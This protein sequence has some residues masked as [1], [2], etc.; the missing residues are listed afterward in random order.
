MKIGILTFHRVVNDGS[1]MQAFCLY[2]LLKEWI[3][4]ASIEIVDYCPATLWRRNH[5]ALIPRRWPF[6]DRSFWVK[7]R[8]GINFLR[9]N[10]RLSEESLVSDS[11]PRARAFVRRQGYDAVI[12]GSDTVWDTRKNGGAPPPPNVYFLPGLECEKR[13]AF[14]VSMDK[15]HPG[16]LAAALWSG[17]VRDLDGFVFISV[18]DEATRRHLIAGGLEP[19][20]IQFLADPTVHVDFSDVLGDVDMLVARHQPLAGVAVSD[21]DLRRVITDQFCQAGYQVINLL[22][23]TA[24]GQISIPRAWSLGQRVAVH[25]ELQALITDRFHAAVFALKLGRARVLMVE[26][27]AFYPQ[28]KSKGRDLF[29]R[30]GMEERVWRFGRNAEIPG[31]LVKLCVAPDHDVGAGAAPVGGRLEKLTTGSSGVLE[32]LVAAVN[33]AP[34]QVRG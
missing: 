22:G 24:R 34:L 18:R 10:C 11:L 28:R 27:E 13:L 33:G 26:P 20:R 21:M 30:L 25:G 15:G 7:M 1:V 6:F 4:E 8:S 19:S 23:Y 9:R 17:I 12:T 2:R 31:D 3:P 29:R 14:A 32:S 16:E 5:R